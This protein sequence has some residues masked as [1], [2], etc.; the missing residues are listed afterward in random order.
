MRYKD[1]WTERDFSPPLGGGGG[2][3]SSIAIVL[4]HTRTDRPSGP[5]SDDMRLLRVRPVAASALGIEPPEMR[6]TPRRDGRARTLTLPAALSV[7][8]HAAALL[9]AMVFLP[10]RTEPPASPAESSIAMVFAP[11]PAD[12]PAAT[13][14]APPSAETTP[15]APAE[16]S[17]EPPAGEPSP[18]PV[19][20]APDVPA[21]APIEPPAPAPL[22][23]VTPP[24]EKTQPAPEEPP[25][26]AQKPPPR[27]PA[28]H[29]RSAPT[30][31][32]VAAPAEQ[33]SAAVGFANPSASA[34]IVPPR[35]VAGMETNRAPTYPESARRRG[36][37]GRVVLRVSVSSEGAPLDVEVMGTSGHPS[38]DSAALSAVRQWRF[39]PATQAG[40][41]VAA[42]AEVPIR[43]QLSN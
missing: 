6:G 23:A 33:Q 8:A 34:A 28:A 10:A 16:H 29:A 24:S 5:I 30:T 41:S 9:V 13:D 39:I 1:R 26:P 42:V 20:Q 19:A 11:A 37:Q 17:D 7:L 14:V 35:P 31:P 2:L 43:F 12:L 4:M 40:R 22:T 32:H 3:F 27:Q 25:P 38:L 15:P 36:E 21:P 18:P